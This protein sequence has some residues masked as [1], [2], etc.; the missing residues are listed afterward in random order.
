MDGSDVHTDQAEGAPKRGGARGKKRKASAK[1]ADGDKKKRTTRVSRVPAAPPPI[2]ITTTH[3]ALGDCGV[4]RIAALLVAEDPEHVSRALNAL[5]KASA[6]V[7]V[8]YCLGAGG[9]KVIDALCQLFDET[10]GWDN[11]NDDESEDTGLTSLEPNASHWGE[12]SLSGMHKRWREFCRAKLTSPLSS[13]SDPSLFIDRQSEA[14]ILDMIIA[15]LRNLS[16]VAQNLRFM[17]QSENAVRVLTGALYYRGYSISQGDDGHSFSHHSNICVYAIQ[18]LTNMAPLID[19]TGRQLFIDRVFLESNEKEIIST[20]PCLATSAGS[21]KETPMYGIA[22]HL[23]FGGM[24]LA[25]QYDTR[26]ETIDAISNEMVWSMAGVG[27]HVQTT[28][29]IFPA[30]A[31]VM[32]PND[33]TTVTTSAAGWHRP[34]LQSM[35]ELMIALIENTDNKGIFANVPDILLHQL[36]EMLYLQRLGPESLDYIDPI[37]HSVVRVIPLKLTTGYDAFIDADIR[38]RACELLVKLTELSPGVRRRLGM[39]PAIRGM[40]HQESTPSPSSKTQP[41]ANSS[42]NRINVRL[43]DSIISMIST[44]SGRSDAGSLASQLLANMATVPENKAG[45]LYCERKLI[46]VSAMSSDV[47]NVACNSIFNRIY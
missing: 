46:S 33:T 22:S 30:L 42:P 1:D 32:D 35:L 25:K 31:A 39:A 17:V 34:S 24:H 44:S 23:G 8:N 14:P 2:D 28:L 11:S 27:S 29:A 9:E 12:E 40:S 10:I 4:D 41:G 15:I 3:P 38:D 19:V 37:N 5:L 36:T 7:E 21:D 47:A 18:T 45:I 43:F 20:V 26:A 13:S 6:D 16:F